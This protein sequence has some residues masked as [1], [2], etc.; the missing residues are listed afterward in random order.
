MSSSRGPVAA[1]V[2]ADPQWREK[3]DKVYTLADNENVKRIGPPYIPERD[4]FFK[5]Q[6]SGTSV[7][8]GYMLLRFE[9]GRA[10][11]YSI[12]SSTSTQPL[13]SLAQRLCGVM[14]SQLEIPST[15]EGINSIA[16]DWIFRPTATVA[17]RMDGL[18]AAVGEALNKKLRFEKQQV[19]R[20]VVLVSGTYA[21]KPLEGSTATGV[22]LFIDRQDPSPRT[23]QTS[24]PSLFS[25]L[26][27][28]TGVQFVSEIPS[29]SANSIV[30]I[31]IHQS[32][33][34]ARA[35]APVLSDEQLQPLLDNLSKQTGLE[36]KK[37]KRKTD[38][39][40]LV[41]GT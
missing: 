14:T 22:Q 1:F 25:Q 33:L 12:G 7:T 16:G 21:F 4:T 9:N 15:I 31:G 19:D 6:I 39:W 38:I 18:G 30:P 24:L 35:A 20:D 28:Y 26:T 34:Q 23:T 27:S 36:F 5:V 2:P 10:A 3:F 32:L 17:D 40:K 41:E 8:P 37:D 13:A 29:G 11:L